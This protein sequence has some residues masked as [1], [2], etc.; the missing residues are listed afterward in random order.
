MISSPQLR[1]GARAALIVVSVVFAFALSL[2]LTPPGLARPAQSTQP[3][4]SSPAAGTPPATAD[5]HQEEMTSRDTQTTF[6]VNVML[7]VVRVVVRDSQGH[8]VGNLQKD[9]F[10]LFDNGKPQVISQFSLEQPGAQVAR[11]QKTSDQPAETGN[12][13]N[14]PE[15]FVAYFFDDLHMRNEDLLPVRQAA[16]HHLLSLQPTDRAG[17]FTS[18]G[19]EMMDFTDD[20]GRLHQ[21]LLQ[22][23][24]RSFSRTGTQQCPYMTYYMADLIANQ[25]DQTALDAAASDALNCDIKLSTSAALGVAPNAVDPQIQVARQMAEQAALQQLSLGDEEARI[26]LKSLKDLERRVSTVLGQRTIVLVSPGFITPRLEY[27][28]EEAIERA[29][30]FNIVIGTLD[31]RGLY[32]SLPG[33]DVSSEYVP[34]ANAAPQELLYEAASAT[35]NSQVL[36]ELADAT[37]GVFVHNNN[38]F[39]EGFRRTAATPEHY[40]VLGF[41]PQNLKYDGRLHQLKVKLKVPA[42]LTV[43][44]RKGYYAPKHSP[45]AAEEAKHEIEDALFSQ[46]EMHDLPVELHTQFF[47]T[48]DLDAKLAVLVRVDVKHLHFRK[49]EGRNRNDLTIVSGLFDRNGT[50]VTGSEKV[51]EMR[52]KDETLEKKL[53]SGVT[54]KT[55]YDVKPGSYL[56]RLVV[57]DDEGQLS[58]EN[59][60]IEI[61]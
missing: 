7:V 33:C 56:V 14:I 18:S 21:A 41:S 57:R 36:I 50:Y 46:E 34:N 40:Y 39:E 13:P 29:I 31:A 10:Q 17:I 1:I 8:T 20:H 35:A 47:K 28:L 58:A 25:H 44:A 9:D 2:V 52:L 19:Q 5:N 26:T 24:P 61:Q 32:A 38:D 15:R 59:G 27:D 11:E 53:A 43:Q 16:D 23:Q 3:P 60:A 4:A 48:N 51:L 12:L 30:R 54:V 42:K 22:I 55:S 49:E 37:G 45:D 6:K